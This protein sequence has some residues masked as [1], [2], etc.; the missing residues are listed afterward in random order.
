MHKIA[1]YCIFTPNYI[2]QDSSR[3][4]LNLI[5]NKV[6]L[7]RDHGCEASLQKTPCLQRV[8]KLV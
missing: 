4:L 5:F 7:Y 6:C 3:C 8:K 2:T 1:I